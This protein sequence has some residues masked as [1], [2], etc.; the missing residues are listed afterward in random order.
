VADIARGHE[1]MHRIGRAGTVMPRLDQAIVRGRADG[2]LTAEDE[3]ELRIYAAFLTDVAGLPPTLSTYRDAVREVYRRHY[4]CR[5]WTV[6]NVGV[7]LICELSR[8]HPG[9]DHRAL[10]VHWR[11]GET[12]DTGPGTRRRADRGDLVELCSELGALLAALAAGAVPGSRPAGGR[13]TVP[14]SRPPADIEALS[15]AE[16]IETTVAAMYVEVWKAKRFAYL[17][18]DTA[19]RLRRLPAMVEALPADDPLN[20]RVPALLAARRDHARR[21]LGWD[22]EMIWLRE[23]PTT[24]LAPVDVLT[25]DGLVLADTGCWAVDGAAMAD[26]A[27]G[28]GELPDDVREICARARA[29]GDEPVIWRRSRLGIP[30]GADMARADITCRACGYRSRPEDRAAEVLAWIQ[31]TKET[32]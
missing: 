32:R 21:V 17:P 11:S 14:A 10:G 1:L 16:D 29:A 27:T 15:A 9:D 20:R 3:P 30:R 23:C 6:D 13:R 4:M 28:A 12:P 8:D 5:A 7:R 22:D 26:E 31:T 19:D 18:R 25:R 2:L 24:D